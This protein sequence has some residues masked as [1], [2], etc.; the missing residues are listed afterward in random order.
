M[1]RL[2]MAILG[3]AAVATASD[4][5]WYEI[6]VG[7]T[8]LAG[9][10]TGALML[11]AVGAALGWSA[12]RLVAGLPLGI[13]AGVGGAL[14]YYGIGSMMGRGNYGPMIPAWMLCWIILAIG[15]GKILRSRPWGEIFTRGIAAAILSG[16]AFYAVS[17]TLWGRPPAGG[18]NYLVQFAMWVGAWA[19]GMLAIGLGGASKK[20]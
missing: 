10:I 12:G 16:L 2:V 11:G 17:G 6:G 18:R 1:L 3:V 9:V 7:H 15:E 8:R 14:A 4:Y 13:F 20:R 19:P 5:V